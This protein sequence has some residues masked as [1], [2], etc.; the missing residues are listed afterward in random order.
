MSLEEGLIPECMCM[1][2]AENEWNNTCI[3]EQNIPD[4]VQFEQMH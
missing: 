3:S 4:H 2:Y 1:K